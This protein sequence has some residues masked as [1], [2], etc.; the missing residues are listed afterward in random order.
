MA[1][2]FAGDLDGAA[3]EFGRLTGVEGFAA[4]GFFGLA[5]VASKRGDDGAY[6]QFYSTVDALDVGL[7]RGLE[8]LEAAGEMSYRDV[9][10]VLLAA[11]ST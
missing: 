9:A 8:G 7:A 4:D 2:F 3:F 10:V 11:Q 6:L 5:L 1:K